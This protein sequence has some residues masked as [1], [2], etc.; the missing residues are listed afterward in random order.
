M[1]SR[2][3]ASKVSKNILITGVPGI[4]KT[5][6]V[7]RVIENYSG[8]TG[9]FYTQEIRHRGQRQGFEIV[10][11]DGEHATL[12]HVD[13]ESPVKVSKYGVDISTLD[14]VAVKAIQSALDLGELIV[15][16]EIGPMEIA[17]S[18]FREVLI[19]SLDS[20][21]NILATIAKRS[22][23][24]TDKIRSR[25]DIKLIEVTRDN[26]DQLVGVILNML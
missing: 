4:G 16:D 22:R 24:F 15:I 10:T 25:P 9:G 14:E 21:S 6:L 26:R 7:Q 2:I 3:S 19:K 1:S 5:T 20:N 11:L 12:A 13:I 23:S 17:S 8:L 18:R